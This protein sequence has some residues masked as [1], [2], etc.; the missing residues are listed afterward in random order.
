MP[1]LSLLALAVMINEPNEQKFTPSVVCGH[2][3]NVTSADRTC[4]AKTP[5]S[6]ST[7]NAFIDPSRDAK[8]NYS[9]NKR[10]GG[11]PSTCCISRQIQHLLLALMRKLVGVKVKVMPPLADQVAMRALLGDLAIFDHQNS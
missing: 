5:T 3:W 2:I 4:A 6:K 11:K 7:M 10:P 1:P 8:F 9:T